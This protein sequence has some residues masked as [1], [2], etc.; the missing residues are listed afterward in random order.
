[1]VLPPPPPVVEEPKPE[2]VVEPEPEPVVEPD[3]EPVVE[4][5]PENPDAIVSPNK[6]Q[7]VGVIYNLQGIRVD[8]DQLQKGDLYIKEGK[9]YVKN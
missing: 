1:M 3:P 5:D 7:T 8:F 6:D 2:P 4:P 9:K